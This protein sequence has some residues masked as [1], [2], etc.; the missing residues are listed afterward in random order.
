MIKLGLFLRW[1]LLCA[2]AE[3][4]GIAAAALWYGAANVLFGEP[5]EFSA[6]LAVWLVMSLA[7]VPEG[8]I[9]G[10]LQATGIRWFIPKVSACK[11]ILA[12]VA[13]GFLGWAIGIAVPMFLYTVEGHK[14]E[15][16]PNLTA[17]AGFATAFG[18]SVGAVFG[19]AQ[20][21]VLP[22]DTQGKIQ[23]TLANAVGWAIA[24]PLIYA[25]AQLAA[26]YHGW[27]MRV[28]VWAIGG[29]AAGATIGVTTAGALYSMREAK[30]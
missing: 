11:W 8:L 14:I 9:L 26:E 20:A 29:L 3:F 7:A 16:Q 22:T 21:L 23:W 19:L 17:T 25:A 13:V 30:Q 6:R 5:A 27:P 2:L 12:T 1:V 28:A 10:G 24:L 15:P 18:A 4:L